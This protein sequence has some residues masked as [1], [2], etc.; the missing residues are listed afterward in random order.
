MMLFVHWWPLLAFVS[1]RSY[2]PL[3]ER[4]VTIMPVYEYFCRSC[5]TRYEKLRSMSDADAPIDCPECAEHDS[6]R[7]LSVFVTHTVGSRSSA[8]AQES[9]STMSSGGCGCGHC[10]CGGSHSLN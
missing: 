1:S 7:V 9:A 8:S 6:V 5:N 4:K 2:N 3:Y 10:T